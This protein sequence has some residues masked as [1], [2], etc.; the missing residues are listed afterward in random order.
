MFDHPKT[1]H[2]QMPPQQVDAGVGGGKVRV[3]AIAD[4]ADHAAAI[5]F[6]CALGQA[7]VIDAAQAHA[8]HQHHRQVERVHQGGLVQ[9]RCQRREPAAHAFH[10]AR[11]REHRE[12]RIGLAQRLQIHLDALQHGGDFRRGRFAQGD[13][14]HQRIRRR[15]MAGI[16]QGECVGVVPFRAD[17]FATA[18]DG[19][20]SHG[21]PHP[22]LQCAQQ[23]HAGDGL[24]DAGVGA[25]DVEGQHVESAA[26]VSERA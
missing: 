15:G 9:A 6:D 10:N 11:G 20:H 2:R 14:I 23:C 24:S 22:R 5:G 13:R 19:L 17:A 3:D 18:G 12:P 25:G 16:A 1:R 21:V 8:H 26:V 7:R 4:P